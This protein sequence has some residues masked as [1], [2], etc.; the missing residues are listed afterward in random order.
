[1]SE[2]G[3]SDPEEQAKGVFQ[4]GRSSETALSSENNRIP[5]SHVY[6]V[7]LSTTGELIAHTPLASNTRLGSK[8]SPWLR[9]F[10]SLRMQLT[11][12]V[13]FL[14]TI[15]MLLTNTLYAQSVSE[16]FL[17]LTS[18]GIVVLG[19]ALA[20]VLISLLLRPLS[21][22]T[23]AAQAIAL[24]D[25]EQRERLPLRLPPQ[26]EIDRLA[27]S[28]DEMATRLEHAEELRHASEQRF[29]QFLSDASHELRTPL[30]SLRGFTEVLM[31][32]AT[33]DP[34]TSQRVLKL[35][36]NEAERMTYLINDLLTLSRLDNSGPIKTQYIDLIELAHEG[37]EQTRKRA[38]DNRAIT[39][40]VETSERLGL[41]ANEE[42]LKQLIFVLLDNALKYGRSTPDGIVRLELDRQDNMAIIRISDNGEGIAKDDLTHIFDSF[43]RGRRQKVSSDG[44]T[45]VG[46][47]LGLTIAVSI[48]RAHHGKLSVSSEAGKGTTFTVQ[49]PCI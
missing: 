4:H 27:G 38:K 13:F 18:I 3:I 21:R 17:A 22:V 20:F 26:D 47:G 42:R 39:L 6:T 33:S 12:V 30:T 48:V 29:T 11:F 41:Q 8:M 23:D 10:L 15:A 45:V 1:M 46:T 7:D 31:R 43:Y 19:T 14:L 34:E 40:S 9:P 2:Q 37:I 44:T 16:P 36:K 35:M 5:E 28:L 24:G 49:L 25:F 32:G